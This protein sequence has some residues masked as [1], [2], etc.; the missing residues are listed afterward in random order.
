MVLADAVRRYRQEQSLSIDEL[1]EVLE[2]SPM[3]VDWIEH[4]GLVPRLHTFQRI[5]QVLQWTPE[6]AAIVAMD[7][8]DESPRFALAESVRDRAAAL[9][10]GDGADE[11]RAREAHGDRRGDP[12]A[13]HHRNELGA[14]ASGAQPSG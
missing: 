10:D 5:A 13:V 3:T 9:Q 1:A 2:V 8:P 4:A 7:L 12:L 6:E 11:P 14:V